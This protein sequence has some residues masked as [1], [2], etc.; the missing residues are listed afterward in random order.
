MGRSLLQKIARR[1]CTDASLVVLGVVI[2]MLVY[3]RAGRACMVV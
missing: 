3:A 2:F 1:N